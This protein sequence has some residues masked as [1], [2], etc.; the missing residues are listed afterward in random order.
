MAME[1]CTTQSTPVFRETV[2]TSAEL[3]TIRQVAGLLVIACV[4]AAA[5]GYLD[6]YAY[7]A[8]GHV[9]AN[10]QTGNV[11]FFAVFASGRRW[12]DALRHLPPI[13]AFILG[14]GIA[15]L[16]G[17][18]TQKRYFKPTLVCQAIELGVLCLLGIF[19]PHLPDPVVVPIISFVAALQNT[20]FGAIGPWTFAS[21]MTT[22]NISNATSGFV[23]WAIGRDRGENR[24]RA[25]ISSCAS[26]SFLLGALVGGLGTRM[27]ERYAL[28]P[29]A[30]IVLIGFL[31]TWRQ[32]WRN[33]R[34][35]A[36]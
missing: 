20:S 21:A 2:T 35:L 29:C 28:L 24:G 15:R 31:L 3:M 18:R 7:L 5:G 17:V 9:F 8:H 26:L 11:V 4:F 16:L 10:A 30:G 23:M 34:A 1:P 13:A 19:S 33:L 12:K 36:V 25:I 32:R 27:H 6:A 22:G 14:V